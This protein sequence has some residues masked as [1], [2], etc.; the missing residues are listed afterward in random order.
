VGLFLLLIRLLMAVAE[1]AGGTL[2]LVGVGLLVAGALL[3]R[4]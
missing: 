1:V 3:Q 4:R 2:A